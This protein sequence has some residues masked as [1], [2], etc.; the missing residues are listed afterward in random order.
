[1]FFRLPGTFKDTVAFPF[2]KIN[3]FLK[4]HKEDVIQ[5]KANRQ[6]GIKLRITFECTSPESTLTFWCLR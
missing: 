3:A 6:L 1:M 2:H 4:V 5:P